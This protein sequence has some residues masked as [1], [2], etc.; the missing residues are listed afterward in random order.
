MAHF[1]VALESLF[2]LAVHDG[3]LDMDGHIIDQSFSAFE[4]SDI[5]RLVPDLVILRR[6]H[7][8]KPLDTVACDDKSIQNTPIENEFDLYFAVF[9]LREIGA[10]RL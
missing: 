8:T 10:Q 9:N 2:K 5:L 1:L 7:K 6:G 3:F 4:R